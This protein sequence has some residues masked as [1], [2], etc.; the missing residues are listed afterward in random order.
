[1]RK[2]RWEQLNEILEKNA[3]KSKTSGSTA[4]SYA[5]WSQLKSVLQTTPYHQAYKKIPDDQFN[6]LSQYLSFATKCFDSIMSGKESLRRHMIAPIIICVCALFNGNVQIE[7]EEDLD[8]DFVKAH[9]HFEFVLRRGSKRVCIVEAKRE[10]MDQ[11]LAQDLLGCEVAAEIDQ[12]NLVYGIVTNYY[13]WTFL[14][15]LDEKIER[16]D[17]S[18]E[19]NEEGPL[20]SSLLNITGKIYAMLSD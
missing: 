13:Q 9:G 8:G 16:H 6:V 20:Q 19:I 10:D 5:S 17:F 3:K 4:Y 18:M 14:R 11:G 15:S 7:V 12:L 2:K 1:M